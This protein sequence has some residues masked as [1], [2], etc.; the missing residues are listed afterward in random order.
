MLVWVPEGMT[1]MPRSATWVTP[2][3]VA[4]YALGMPRR[5]KA[6][7]AGLAWAAIFALSACDDGKGAPCQLDSDCPSLLEICLDQ[8][9]TDPD[10]A[11]DSGAEETD[12]GAT[13]DSGASG[14]DSGAPM[15]AGAEADAGEMVDAAVTTDA[16]P[17]E[18]AGNVD[19]GELGTDAGADED[20]GAETDAGEPDSGM[21]A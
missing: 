11:R 9:C 13:A 16:A 14:L 2:R 18:D 5:V 7:G 3:R 4:R 1:D 21:G 8:R 17:E 20:A 19:A 10:E 15:D 12:A 6:L